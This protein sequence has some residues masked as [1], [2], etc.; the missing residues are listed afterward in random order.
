MTSREASESNSTL[1]QLIEQYYSHI[2]ITTLSRRCFNDGAGIDY[3]KKYGLQEDVPGLLVGVSPKFYC[4]AA[5][6]GTFR[7]ILENEDFV[8]ADHTIK[9]SYQGAEGTVMIGENLELVINTT[10]TRTENTLLGILDKTCTQMGKRLLRMNILQPPCCLDIIM[11]RLD[12]VDEL[13]E[14]E[15]GLFN[16]QSSL[17][18]LVDLDHSIAFIVK[19]PKVDR[20]NVVSYLP[21]KD[22]SCIL[23]KTIHKILSDPAFNEFENAISWRQWF[24][25]SRQAYKEAIEDI[26]ELVVEYSGI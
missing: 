4:L 24:T 12:A 23:I 6:S 26:Y 22:D 13:F 15:E 1:Y 16:I 10:N 5:T 9:F 3:I 19:V 11:D 20:K 14:S 17:K 7:F 18:S 2:T 21:Y 8:F 25:R